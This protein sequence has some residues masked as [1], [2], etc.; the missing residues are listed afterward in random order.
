MPPQSAELCKKT[1]FISV[2]GEKRGQ[3]GKNSIKAVAGINCRTW[4]FFLQTK[5][6]THFY[7]FEV[8][9]VIHI[10]IAFFCSNSSKRLQT[11][12]RTHEP[13]FHK[14]NLTHF[15]IY[16]TNLCPKIFKAPSAC[17]NSWS[18]KKRYGHQL[19]PMTHFFNRPKIWPTFLYLV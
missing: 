11:A 4:P 15:H 1:L 14:K 3:I 18:K 8:K 9:C 6:L 13:L 19:E 17:P 5:N 2:F 12:T 7:I 16:G 10:C